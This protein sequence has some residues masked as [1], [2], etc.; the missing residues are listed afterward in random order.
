[1]TIERQPDND[2]AKSDLHAQIDELEEGDR[3]VLI[4][5]R[6]GDE[7]GQFNSGCYPHDM[8]TLEIIG[9][10]SIAPTMFVDKDPA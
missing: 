1:M 5:W 8:P 3:A 10:C 9:L 7:L 4:T 2:A 6:D